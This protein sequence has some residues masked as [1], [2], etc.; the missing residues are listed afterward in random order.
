MKEMIH[1]YGAWIVFLVSAA[2]YA[3][4]ALGGALGFWIGDYY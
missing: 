1:Q 2:I 3:G 4:A